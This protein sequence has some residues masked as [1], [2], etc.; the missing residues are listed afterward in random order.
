MRV[1]TERAE[2]LPTREAQVFLA[3]TENV[4]WA[5]FVMSFGNYEIQFELKLFFHRTQNTSF[6]IKKKI[7]KKNL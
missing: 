2:F 5:Y 3:F 6:H 4:L 7:Q 1:L